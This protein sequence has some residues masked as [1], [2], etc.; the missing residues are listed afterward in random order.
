MF[1]NFQKVLHTAV[2]VLLLSA[3]AMA[4]VEETYSPGE[5]Y[6]T[7][8]W[9]APMNEEQRAADLQFIDGMRPHHAG[10]LTMSDEY[11]KNNEASN[12]QLLQLARGIIHNQTFEIEMM[13]RVE[14]YVKGAHAD[15]GKMQRLAD[16]DLVQ[17]KKFFRAPV[18]GP[19]DRWAGSR[20]VSKED[21]RFAKAMIVHHEGALAMAKDFLSSSSNNGYL[22]QMCLDILKDQSIE[23]AFMHSI[24][25]Q[26][27]GNPDDVKI[28]ASMVHG[29]DGMKHAMPSM[30][31]HKPARNTVAKPK[32][33]HSA[34][35]HDMMMDHSEHGM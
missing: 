19:L 20:V 22:R 31:H 34:M 9:Y 21:V 29:M 10:A 30:E 13:D 23:I 14:A 2:A 25:N 18:P 32:M 24:I 16:V 27:E 28:D 6:A 35:D 15:N 11:L 17:K 33:D 8:P 12:A 4:G 1:H 3:P 7:T 26:Y 5:P